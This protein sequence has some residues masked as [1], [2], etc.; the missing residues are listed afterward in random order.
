MHALISWLHTTALSMFVASHSW[1]W[2]TCETLHFIGLILLIGNVGLLDLRMLGVVKDLPAKPLNR[3]VL[4]GVL[5]FAINLA[6]GVVFFVGMPEQYIGNAAFYLKLLFMMLAGLNVA[7]FYVT[8]MFRKVDRL[9]PGDEAPPLAKVIAAAS[10]F[11][12]FGVMYFG[13]MLPYLG[14]AF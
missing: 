14:N 7:T 6:T 10:L 2:P 13:R 1:V 5:G 4:W 11:L 12:W 3:F 9:A 8:G